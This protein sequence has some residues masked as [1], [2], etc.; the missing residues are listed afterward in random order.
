MLHFYFSQL[1]LMVSDK[2]LPPAG[3]LLSYST[4]LVQKPLKNKLQQTLLQTSQALPYP[5]LGI[6]AVQ[7]EQLLS[8]FRQAALVHGRDNFVL[9]VRKLLQLLQFISEC[10]QIHCQIIAS[11]VVL[12]TQ[13]HQKWTLQSNLMLM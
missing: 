11:R 4:T 6:C 8:L 9:P 13:L 7:M 12:R 2:T 3:V 10:R 1:K 5:V